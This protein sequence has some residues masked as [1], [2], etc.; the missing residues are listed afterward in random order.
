[1]KKILRLGTR[2]SPLA[3]VQAK[4]VRDELLR[5]VAELATTHEIELVPIHTSGDWRP[6]Q[7]ERTFMEMGGN[8]GLF[9]K[10]IE[11]ALAA[12]HVDFAVHSMKDVATQGPDGLEFV[13]ALTRADP[14]DAFISSKASTLDGL[15]SG[16][17]VGTASLRRQAQILAR[18]PDL[19]VTPLRGNVETRLRKLA[20][21]DADAT[22]LA[23]AGL[24][25]LG[26]GDRITSIM[27]VQTMLP[28]AAQGVI[29]VQIRSDDV[30]MRQ[31]AD[32][33]NDPPTACCIAAERALLK[34]LDGSCRTPV[35]AYA[36]TLPNDRLTLDA[37]VANPDGTGMLRLQ[38][39]GLMNDAM[40]I[41]LDLG[42]EIKRQMPPSAVCR[43]S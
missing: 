21:G 3:L 30:A 11:E 29:G 16:A 39:Q 33:I 20:A 37:L 15:P 34:V 24:A 31:L 10:E 8:K 13:A 36:Q 38:R 12:G 9:T 32:A 41:G 6:E 43:V 2:G 25:R 40:Q 14:R 26:F 19:R 4:L 5:K 18:R 27:D 28:S 35:A 1:M 22:I 23:V 7:K 17:V 42:A